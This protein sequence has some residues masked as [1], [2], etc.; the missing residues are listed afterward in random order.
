MRAV[1]R[2][3][4][5]LAARMTIDFDQFLAVLR[6]GRGGRRCRRVGRGLLLG[7]RARLG[8]RR[9]R[10]TF[11]RRTLL[12]PGGDTPPHEGV[13][14]MMMAGRS[15]AIPRVDAVA[16]TAGALKTAIRSFR[17]GTERP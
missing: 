11:G 10:T 16:S 4:D 13:D 7:G 1:A 15:P 14:I 5:S 17:F 6:L 12:L 8:R 2:Q 3:P 9:G